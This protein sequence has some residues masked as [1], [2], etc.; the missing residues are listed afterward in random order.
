MP[1]RNVKNVIRFL[2]S[3]ATQPS[4]TS[5][6]EKTGSMYVQRNC[7]FPISLKLHYLSSQDVVSGLLLPHEVEQNRNSN[8]CQIREKKKTLKNLMRETRKSL[9]RKKVTGIAILPMK[10]IPHNPIQSNWGHGW[11]DNTIHPYPEK[12]FQR[13]RLDFLQAVVS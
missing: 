10:A 12:D 13:S 1:R 4:D 9:R 7:R 8:G 6:F 11:L 2:F 3:V 5:N